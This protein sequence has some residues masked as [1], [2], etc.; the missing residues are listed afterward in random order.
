MKTSPISERLRSHR[1]A[2]GL[3][4]EALARKLGVAAATVHRWESGLEVA[5]AKR[6]VLEA[7]LASPARPEPVQ[8]GLFDQVLTVSLLER[9]A[10][11]EARVAQLS[12]RQTHA[13]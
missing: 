5:P 9:L 2:A 8:A 7:W 1:L 6:A 10:Q 11:L 12:E 4:Q 13:A 3:S